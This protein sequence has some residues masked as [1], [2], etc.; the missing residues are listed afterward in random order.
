MYNFE[1]DMRLK[2]LGAILIS[3]LDKNSGRTHWEGRQEAFSI[4]RE[5]LGFL[6][7]GDAPNHLSD[8]DLRAAILRVE[9]MLAL[10]SVLLEQKAARCK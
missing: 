3:H 1:P 9:G 7:I 10:M 5:V 2:E 4:A 6:P 8:D